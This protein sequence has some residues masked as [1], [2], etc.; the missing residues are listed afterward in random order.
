MAYQLH[1]DYKKTSGGYIKGI[2]MEA[3]ATEEYKR[4][5]YQGKKARKDEHLKVLADFITFFTEKMMIAH[6]RA[7]QEIQNTLFKN[8]MKNKVAKELPQ[9]NIQII[10]LL[11]DLNMHDAIDIACSVYQDF[12][13][14]KG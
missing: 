11:K 12:R 14:T 5:Y 3:A 7:A 2:A 8:W 6:P 10:N 1:R 4:A 13:E 9:A